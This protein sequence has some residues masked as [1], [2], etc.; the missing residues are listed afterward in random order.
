MVTVIEV[1]ML[2]IILALVAGSML[3][4]SSNPHWFI[5]GWDF[6]RVQILVLAWSA[7]AILFASEAVTGNSPLLPRWM[8]LSCAIGLTA[9]HGFRILPYTRVLPRQAQ[10]T[11]RHKRQDHHSD[12][13]SIRVVV[14]NVEEE[15][16]QYD[17]WRRVIGQ[18]DPD[19]LI[20]L[21]IN[22]AWAQAAGP[23]FDRYAH[24]IIQTQDNWYGM[25]VL[26]RLP[27]R[28]Q[29]IRYLVQDDIPSI[30]AEIQLDDDR[31]IRL[32]AVHPRP[33]EP[34]RDNDAI[35]RDAE[36][37]L[38]GQELSEEDRPTIIGGDLNDVAWSSTTRLF[39]RVSGMLDPRRGRGFF[40][41]FH[42]K[43]WFCRFPLDHIFHSPHFTVSDI[44]RL[45]SIGS[46][47]F[48]IL[49]DLRLEPERR[50]EHEIL[51]EQDSDQEEVEVRLERACDAPEANGE[52]VLDS[53]VHASPK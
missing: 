43:Y 24:R 45:P 42:A 25:M 53:S 34:W 51:E 21:E 40:N 22:E 1:L 37:T 46:D 23:L 5:R 52:A 32:I 38:W 26:S 39:L 4:L 29:R 14:S 49:I 47:H 28:Q 48:P 27:I 33:P 36:L 6:P 15:N 50:T 9:W 10:S 35:A 16:Q 20:A 30:D 12:P 18:A 31:I 44:H 13:S 7:A 11:A 3:N 8:P 2:S 19:I 41:T 17:R